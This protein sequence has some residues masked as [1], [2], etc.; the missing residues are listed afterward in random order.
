[1]REIKLTHAVLQAA[2]RLSRATHAECCHCRRGVIIIWGSLQ[3]RRATTQVMLGLSLRA[4][5]DATLVYTNAAVYY[6]KCNPINVL[7]QT[8]LLRIS[9]F[10]RC[11]HTQSHYVIKMLVHNTK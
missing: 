3:E 7:N 1:M 6:Q 11:I 10:T 2:R 5:L 8:L 4:R 9:T